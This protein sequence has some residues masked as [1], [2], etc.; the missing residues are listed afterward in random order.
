MR[1]RMV[2]VSSLLL[3]FAGVSLAQGWITYVDR[4]ERFVVNFPGEPEIRDTSY[5]SHF[6]ATFPARV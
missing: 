4:A 2:T 1:L 5:V 6:N 3:F